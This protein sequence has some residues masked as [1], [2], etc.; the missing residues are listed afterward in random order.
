MLHRR[1]QLGLLIQRARQEQQH[2]FR[3]RPG[4]GVRIV[5][6]MHWDAEYLR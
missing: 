2:H 3:T 1:M 5:L 4:A 6:Q